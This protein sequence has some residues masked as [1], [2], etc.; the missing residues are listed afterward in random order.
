MKGSP[1]GS[2]TGGRLLVLLLALAVMA[3]ACA[4]RGGRSEKAEESL[5]NMGG[6]VRPVVA[7]LSTRSGTADARSRPSPGMWV[8]TWRHIRIH[9]L[10]RSYLLV[11]PTRV[12]QSRLPVVVVLHGRDMTPALIEAESRFSSVTGPAVLVYPA[13]FDRSWN[14]GYCCGGAHALAVNDVAFLQATIAQ[15]L[16]SDPAASRRVYLVGYSNGGRMAFRMACADP[17]AFAGVAAVE[18][19]PVSACT[20]PVPVPIIEVASSGDPLL[21]IPQSGTPKHIAGHAEVT[22][23]QLIR[24]WRAID[25]CPEAAATTRYGQAVTMRWAD[26]RPGARMEMVEYYGGS[27]AWPNGQPGTP[28]AQQMIWSFFTSGQPGA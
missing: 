25:G 12:T 10:Q 8:S 23:G 24:Q 7:V 5:H 2:S 17:G 21:T 22:V 14:A 27:H 13:G 26:C 11:T 15:V 1:S 28:A 4:G 19:V 16:R 6:R 9:G 20:D 18:A 3:S